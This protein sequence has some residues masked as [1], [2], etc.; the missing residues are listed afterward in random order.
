MGYF[1]ILYKEKNHHFL[2][3]QFQNRIGIRRIIKVQKE[4]IWFSIKNFFGG[5]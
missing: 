5:N 3:Q 2:L 1:S 4:T